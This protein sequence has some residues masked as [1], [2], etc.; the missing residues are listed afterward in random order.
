MLS[1]LFLGASSPV[2]TL[3]S[4]DNTSMLI[5]CNITPPCRSISGNIRVGSCGRRQSKGTTPSVKNG[6]P[7]S[8]LTS[9]WKFF[10]LETLIMAMGD[11]TPNGG[12]DRL[13]TNGK[14]PVASNPCSCIFQ[15]YYIGMRGLKK[16]APNSS[17][18]LRALLYV[19]WHGICAG[20]QGASLKH[21]QVGDV[22]LWCHKAPGLYDRF[23]PCGHEG[24]LIMG[25]GHISQAT[26]CSCL[27]YTL[28]LLNVD[29]DPGRSRRK[30]KLPGPQVKMTRKPKHQEVFIPNKKSSEFGA[31]LGSEA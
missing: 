14:W 22:S 8:A 26:S 4:T 27:M 13:S 20:L 21:V 3:S 19:T 16:S 15:Q 1:F 31:I 7:S 17:Q 12:C 9:T 6:A 29:L 24:K 25:D 11:P 30:P 23:G 2:F 18:N 5:E 10:G 28:P